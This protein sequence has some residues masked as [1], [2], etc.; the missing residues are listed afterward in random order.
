MVVLDFCEAMETCGRIGL[1]RSYRDLQSYWN[2]EPIAKGKCFANLP[3]L[4]ATEPS[5]FKTLQFGER[6]NISTRS[7]CGFASSPLVP[8]VVLHLLHSFR[9]WYVASSPLVSSVN[10]SVK[11]GR[12][13]FLTNKP[14]VSVYEDLFNKS[15]PINGKI[16]GKTTLETSGEDVKLHS[17]RVGKM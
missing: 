11:F 4:S 6:S 17:K 12:D 5:P 7:E 10:F 8:R 14:D 1:L 9:V 16:S 13:A 3:V 2:M 15:G